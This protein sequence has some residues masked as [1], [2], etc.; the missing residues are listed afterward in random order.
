MAF[1]PVF[2]RFGAICL[3]V[4]DQDSVAPILVTA[5]PTHEAIDSVRFIS[6]RSSGR[7]G[8]AIA[9]ASCYR[10]Y[11]TILLLGPNCVEPRKYELLKVVRFRSTVDLEGL[12]NVYWPDRAN[13]LIMAAAVS[14][15]RL[16]EPGGGEEDSSF[17]DG[18]RK[19]RRD[20]TGLTLELESTPDLVADCCVR[21]GSG[22]RVIG[23][24][25]EP[26]EELAERAVAKMKRK[27]LDAI[28]ANPLETIDSD[29]VEATLI[30]ASDG[31]TR[32]PGRVS[33]EAFGNWLIG[34]LVRE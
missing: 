11:E 31:T 34:E 14:D 3:S 22:Q 27:G 9:E 6:N 15:Y 24:A 13:T 20:E 30:A 25:L 28:V 2:L 33:K 17:G 4:M 19:I 23:F 16:K 12:L 26:A 21:K 5:G 10:G 7:M 1:E 8:V 29:E 32:T 18:M